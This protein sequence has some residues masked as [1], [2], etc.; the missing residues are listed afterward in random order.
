[1]G[2]TLFLEPS[3]IFFLSAINTV[4]MRAISCYQTQLPSHP[5]LESRNRPSSQNIPISTD[6]APKIFRYFCR[7]FGL[8]TNSKQVASFGPL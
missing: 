5:V 7:R 4:V 2:F 3:F 1:M 8:W 6:P